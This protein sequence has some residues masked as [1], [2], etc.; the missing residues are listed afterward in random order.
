[1]VELVANRSA[2]QMPEKHDLDLSLAII[3]GNQ[4]A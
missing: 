4:L 1:M 3:Y 2:K